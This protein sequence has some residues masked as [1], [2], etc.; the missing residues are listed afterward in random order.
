MKRYSTNHASE[1]VV[2]LSG[3]E[4]R[5][6]RYAVTVAS[7]KEGVD[8]ALDPDEVKELLPQ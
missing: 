7:Q 4:A 2:G 6:L 1:F 3:E 5:D 8:L